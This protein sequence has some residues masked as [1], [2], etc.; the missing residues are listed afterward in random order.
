MLAVNGAGGAKWVGWMSGACAVH[1]LAQPV[2]VVALPLAAL[3]ER[4]EGAVLL[5]LPLLAG[6]VLWWGLRRHGR[7]GPALPVLG[8]MALWSVA[9]AGAVEEPAKALVIATGGGLSFWGLTWS[10]ALVRLCSGA[11]CRSGKAAG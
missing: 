3:G 5:A 8:G 11:E 6:T 1:C 2:V 9:L 10:G 4:V 7:Y